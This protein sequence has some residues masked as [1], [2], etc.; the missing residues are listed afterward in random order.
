MGSE[1]LSDVLCC[2]WRD[3]L[4]SLADHSVQLCL[5]DMPYGNTQAGWDTR[6]NLRDWWALLRRVMRPSGAVVM[7]AAQP[8]TS[9]LVMSNFHDFK[10]EWIWRKSLPSGHLNAKRQPLRQHESILVFGRTPAYYPQ[11][12]PRLNKGYG[13]TTQHLSDVYGAVSG[14]GERE[15]EDDQGYP[16]TVLDFPTVYHSREPRINPTQKP[17]AL[18]EYLIRT[19][20]APD[21]LV[22]DPFMG[23]GTTAVAARQARRRYVCGD[24]DESQ[25]EAVLERLDAPWQPS[26]LEGA[27]V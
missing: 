4:A 26:L 20:S 7:T 8:F 11:L 2:D 10:H 9:M 21:D 15:I 6:I 27:P 24:I 13:R 17:V 16:L 25:Y 18:F 1:I 19:Y 23:G 14:N 22:I 3:L 12:R 5:A